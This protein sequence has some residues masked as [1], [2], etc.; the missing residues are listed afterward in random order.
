MLF[1]TFLASP[2]TTWMLLWLGAG[3]FMSE[4]H[5]LTFV[6]PF[7]TT[8]LGY[9]DATVM[10]ILLVWLCDLADKPLFT[11]DEGKGQ[12]NMWLEKVFRTH[13][14]TKNLDNTVENVEV[15]QKSWR[16]STKKIKEKFM[17]I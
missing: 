8:L 15:E 11:S 10:Y 14:Q 7:V 16:I 5:R 3:F 4:R 12:V 13:T 9:T 6:I 1:F 2:N 17:K